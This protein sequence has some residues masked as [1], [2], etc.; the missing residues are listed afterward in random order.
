MNEPE[1][2]IWFGRGQDTGKTTTGGPDFMHA[3]VRVTDLGRHTL[4]LMMV[5]G[6]E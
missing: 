4:V 3:G 2:G 1:L 6:L 5:K